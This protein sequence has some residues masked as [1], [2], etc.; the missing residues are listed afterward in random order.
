MVLTHC[1]TQ[2]SFVNKTCQINSSDMR[3]GLFSHRP[4][5]LLVI[6]YKHVKLCK[7]NVSCVNLLGMRYRFLII[8]FTI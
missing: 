8:L 1:Q 7:Y 2:P 4:A 6:K 5:N 3:F